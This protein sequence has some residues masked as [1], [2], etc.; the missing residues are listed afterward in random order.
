MSLLLSLMPPSQHVLKYVVYEYHVIRLQYTNSSYYSSI[1]IY[2]S[3][4]R[5]FVASGI[6]TDTTIDTDTRIV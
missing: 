2:S 4:C 6:S 1:C 3:I 5:Y